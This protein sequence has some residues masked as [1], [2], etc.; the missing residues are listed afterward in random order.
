M[1][2]P[3]CV[4]GIPQPIVVLNRVVLVTGIAGAFLLGAPLVTTALFVI[5]L[6]AVAFGPR[7]S[8][9]HQI[10]RRVFAR[11]IARGVEHEDRRLMRFNNSIALVLLGGAQVAFV[12][13]APL[14]GWVLAALVAVAASVALAGFCVGCFLFYQLKLQRSRLFGVA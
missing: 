7:G 3:T 12:V 8:L 1:S 4:N 5:L 13:G 14:F 11:R 6:G 9:I 2:E 10:G